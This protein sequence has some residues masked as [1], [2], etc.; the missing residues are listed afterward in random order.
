MIAS[1]RPMTAKKARGTAV[2][3]RAR[4]G[5]LTRDQIVDAAISA[6]EEG[7][8]EDMTI[9][10]LA[11][12]LGVAP[13]SL[14]RHIRDKDD[15]LDEITDRLLSTTW[16]PKKGSEDW[17]EWIVANSKRFRHLLV[18]QPAVLHVYLSHPV[19]SPAALERMRF[20]L[21]VLRDAGFSD[22]GARRTYAA[23]HTYTIGFSALEASRSK[24]D[25]ASEKTDAVMRE[26]ATFTTARQFVAGLEMLL[27]G[28]LD[29]GQ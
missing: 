26:L 12:S 21:G 17:R 16:R 29:V 3:R 9:R 24:W 14:Y 13:M 15:L 4:W 6:V 23:L 25:S 11:S 5:S 2:R 7:H 1:Q 27:A 18:T 19:A 20:V 10:S 8:Y 28:A 22:A